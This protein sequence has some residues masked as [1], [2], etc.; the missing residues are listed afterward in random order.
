MKGRNYIKGQNA[1]E[2][3]L[4]QEVGF[5]CPICRT[6]FLTYHHFDPPWRERKHFDPDGVIAL[7]RKHHDMAE[8]GH[9][10]KRYLRDLKSASYSVSDIK[11]Y[12]PWVRNQFIVRVGG[13]YS[14][15]SRT[16]IRVDGEPV[17]QIA[18]GEDGLVSVSFELRSSD[19]NIVA[20]MTNNVFEAGPIVPFDLLTKTTATQIKVWHEARNIGVDVSLRQI[21][22]EKL[23]VTLNTDREQQNEKMAAVRSQM[24]ETL[25]H[26]PRDIAERIKEEYAS[27]TTPQSPAATSRRVSAFRERFGAAEL[28]DHLLRAHFSGDPVGHRVKTWSVANNCTDPDGLISFLNFD[29]LSLHGTNKHV[30]IRDGIRDGIGDVDYNAAIDCDTAFDL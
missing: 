19:G 11:E 10:T 16:V 14:V 29:N 25:R 7:C 17:I 23:E 15:G 8:G 9:Y 2:R 13:L 4:R 24:Q 28:P 5:G 30:R 22:A 27:A 1:A 3:L 18:T 6:P 20:R 12:F 26:L 21:D